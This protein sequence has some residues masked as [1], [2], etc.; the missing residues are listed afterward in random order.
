MPKH[1]VHNAVF[2]NK[3]VKLFDARPSAIRTFGLR[4]EQFL[5]ASDID[6]V[7]HFGNTVI[8]YLTTLVYQTT[9]YCVG[10]SVSQK[11]SNIVWEFE[12]RTVIT[13]LFIQTDHGIGIL[14]HV[15]Q[16]FHRTPNFP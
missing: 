2:D 14:R 7:L 4:I 15:L 1:T 16:F 6:F 10:F 9:Q 11:R 12:T 3:Y 8:F 13:F 5:T